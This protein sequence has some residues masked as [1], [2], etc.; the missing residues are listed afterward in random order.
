MHTIGPSRIAIWIGL[1]TP[2]FTGAFSPR[3]TG[4]SPN[5]EQS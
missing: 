1:R 2:P 4:Q 5:S 3:T